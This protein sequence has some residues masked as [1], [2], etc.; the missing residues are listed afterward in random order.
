MRS[1]RLASA[2]FG[3]LVMAFAATVI[4]SAAIAA[5][6]LGQGMLG[7]DGLVSVEE[8]VREIIHIRRMNPRMLKTV[9]VNHTRA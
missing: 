2:S 3:I 6:A 4:P 8:N 9:R 5:K 1:S 7:K